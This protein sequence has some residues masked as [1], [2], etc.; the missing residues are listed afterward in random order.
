MAYLTADTDWISTIYCA[1]LIWIKWHISICCFSALPL[2][3]QFIMFRIQ[4]LH[5]ESFKP[6]IAVDAQSA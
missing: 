5:N 3:F 4:S 6:L 1:I 2:P